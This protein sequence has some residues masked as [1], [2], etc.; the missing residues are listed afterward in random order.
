MSATFTLEPSAQMGAILEAYPGARRAL[1]RNFHIGGCSSCGFRDDET[2]AEVCKRN[3]D[4]DPERVIGKILQG[5]EEESRLYLGAKALKQMLDAGDDLTLIDVRSRDE[6]EA[7]K[8]EGSVHFNQGLMQE[9][10]A[11]PNKG[12]MLVFYDH[13]GKQVLDAAS[14]FIGHGF[15]TVRCLEGGIDAWAQEIDEKMPRY[16]LE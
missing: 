15:E 5:H 10:M 9:L 4:L 16:V 12:G 8:I 6:H 2:L 3:E 7:V 1:F 14:Y 13:G 11:R